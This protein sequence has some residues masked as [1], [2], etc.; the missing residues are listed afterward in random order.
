MTNVWELAAV[1]ELA[2]IG[3]NKATSFDYCHSLEQGQ[4]YCDKRN[5]DSNSKFVLWFLRYWSDRA[6]GQFM[7]KPLFSCI[8]CMSSVWGSL[9]WWAYHGLTMEALAG[10]PVFVL[11][12]TGIGTII[13]KYIHG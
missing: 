5:I 13:S 1:T 11:A 8:P 10:W 6:F 9:A 3:L 12:L 7:T 4:T 2:I